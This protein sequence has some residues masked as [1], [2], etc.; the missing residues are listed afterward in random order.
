KHGFNKR[1]FFI[2]DFQAP[3]FDVS[4][5]PE[6]SLIKT[7]LVP[8]NANNIDNIYVDSLSFVDPIFQVGQNISLNVRIVNKSE[9]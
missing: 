9:K 3:S 1:M 4:N 5:F 2:S 8:L 7:L 6:D